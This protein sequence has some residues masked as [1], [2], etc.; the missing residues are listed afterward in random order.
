MVVKKKIHDACKNCK[1]ASRLRSLRESVK[2]EGKTQQSFADYLGIDV[3]HIRDIETCRKSWQKDVA[4]KIEEKL[5]FSFKWLM[6]GEGL[7]SD[8][9][10]PPLAPPPTDRGQ[11]PLIEQL[12]ARTRKILSSDAAD[13]SEALAWN[14]KAFSRAVEL[15]HNLKRVMKVKGMTYEHIMSEEVTEPAAATSKP[16]KQPPAAPA[17]G[18]QWEKVDRLKITRVVPESGSDPKETSSSLN[19]NVPDEERKSSE[20]EIM[21][22]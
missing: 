21:V 3:Q 2:P 20:T 7:K 11:E 15:E 1:G 6:T 19:G 12:V 10:P 8:S 22:L 4:L 9:P 5:H 14:I 13:I 17:G 18:N 16:D